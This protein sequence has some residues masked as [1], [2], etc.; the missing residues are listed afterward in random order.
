MTLWQIIGERCTKISGNCHKGKEM[1]GSTEMSKSH[2]I[3]YKLVYDIMYWYLKSKSYGYY[4]GF[5]LQQS[6][7]SA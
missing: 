1:R 2:C 3:I 6:K 4:Q 5:L 7:W